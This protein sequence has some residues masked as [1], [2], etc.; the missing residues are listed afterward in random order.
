MINI[1]VLG[2][3]TVGSGVCRL[4]TQNAYDISKRLGDAINIKKVLDLDAGRV[5]ALGFGE[6]RIAG[7]IDEILGDEDI[8]IVVETMGGSDTA[9]RFISACME[10]G[11]HVVTSNKDL[12]ELRWDE[13]F[14]SAAEHNVDFYFE[15]AVC[16]GIPI[17]APIKNS[18]AANKI[19][20]LVGILNG[21][22]NYILSRMSA[23]G[24]SYREAL[25]LAQKSGFAEADPTSDVSGADAARKLSILARLAFNTRLTL[26]D[27]YREGITEIDSSDIETARSM[28]YT[29]KLVACAS[30][31]GGRI[32][33]FVRPAFVANAHPIASVGDEYNAVFLRGDAVDDVMMYGKGAGSMPTASSVVGDVINVGRN[34]MRGKNSRTAGYCYERREVA[35][36]SEISNLFYLRLTVEDRPRVLSGVAAAFGEQDVSIASLVQRPGPDGSASLIIITHPARERLLRGAVETLMKS[37]YVSRVTTMICIG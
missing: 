33:A 34:I 29:I 21:T 9:F 11:K 27:V 25:E 6:D 10:R 8:Q 5:R 22:T 32:S 2:C 37:D 12:V 1:A 17:I 18:L 16:G 4:V 15:A 28:G 26:G 20:E 13:L 24:I 23:D 3:G 31:E 19:Y 36:I 7:G 35:D 14:A 30:Q